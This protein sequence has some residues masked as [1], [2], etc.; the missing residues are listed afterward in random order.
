MGIGRFNNRIRPLLEKHREIQ[1]ETL[2]VI[3]HPIDWLCESS[4]KIDPLWWVMSD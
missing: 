2:A 4:C 1:L 3:R